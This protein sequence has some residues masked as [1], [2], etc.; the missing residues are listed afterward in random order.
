[1]IVLLDT[2]ALIWAIARRAIKGQPAHQGLSP[3]LLS[4]IGFRSSAPLRIACYLHVFDMC[5]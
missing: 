4:R 1:V 5:I 3:L 2:R